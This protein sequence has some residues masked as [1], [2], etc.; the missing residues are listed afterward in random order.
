MRFAF[1]KDYQ[2]V[3]PITVQCQVLEVSRSGFYTWQGREPSATDR[4]REAL[5]EM[6]H[7]VHQ[8]SRQTSHSNLETLTSRFHEREDDLQATADKLGEHL[9]D[10]HCSKRSSLKYSV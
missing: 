2:G 7:E 9:F 10:V 1:I 6:I 3:W 8:A 5:I 4:R